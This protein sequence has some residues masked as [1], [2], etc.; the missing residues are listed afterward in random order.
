[1]GDVVAP[2]SVSVKVPSTW[3]PSRTTAVRTAFCARAAGLDGVRETHGAAA[4]GATTPDGGG[5]GGASASA[6]LPGTQAAGTASSG[7]SPPSSGS[8]KVTSHVKP[9]AWFAMPSVVTETVGM[10]ALPPASVSASSAA[11]RLMSAVPA[12][13]GG[14]A[15]TPVTAPRHARRTLPA[16]VLPGSVVA[17][18]TVA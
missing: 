13:P 4:G 11:S 7:T 15:M 3:L 10:S 16:T 14:R 17:T 9:P 6:A 1:M 5:G 18:E 12:S 8:E 2:P